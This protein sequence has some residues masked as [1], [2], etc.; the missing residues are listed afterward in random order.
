MKK[1]P[2]AFTLIELL[3]VIA[4]IAVLAALAVPAVGSAM[5]SSQKASTLNSIKQI[6]TLA[7]T[8]AAD[9][10]YRLPAEGG[11]GVQSFG[12]LRT[13]TNAWY[14]VLPPLAGL[15]A[16]S[17]YR[18]NPADFYDKSSVFF[19]GAAS[20]P[21]QKLNSAYFAFGINSQLDHGLSN[22]P[23]GIRVNL[24]RLPHPSRTALFAEAALPDEKH[25]LPSGGASDSLGQPKVRDERFVGRYGNAGII[26][27]AD[28]HAR[29]VSKEQAFDTNVVIW[30]FA[31]N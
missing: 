13:Q 18:A 8:Y 9:N 3:V 27:F 14:N 31:Q 1:Q 20:Y 5:N 24:A 17:N 25:L 23:G 28:G 4:I 22:Q 26:G 21:K 16:A 29:I 30:R 11:D 6:S 2:S 15:K 7:V 12:A 19:V 10:N